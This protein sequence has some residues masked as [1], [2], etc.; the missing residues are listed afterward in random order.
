LAEA[1][2]EVAYKVLD[3]MNDDKKIKVSSINQLAVAFGVAVDKAILLEGESTIIAG[4]SSRGRPD[5]TKLS[6]EELQQYKPTPLKDQAGAD[7]FEHRL[8][9]LNLQ[10]KPLD[11]HKTR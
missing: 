5:L 3:G 4:T 7:G 10:F 9:L 2:R 8:R 1:C 6:D 11:L